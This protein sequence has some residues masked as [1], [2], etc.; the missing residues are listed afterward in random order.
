M[1]FCFTSGDSIYHAVKTMH[2]NL[3]NSTSAVQT[4]VIFWARFRFFFLLAD[5]FKTFFFA[6]AFGFRFARTNWFTNVLATATTENRAEEFAN[7]WTLIAHLWYLLL[8]AYVGVGENVQ[9][10]PIG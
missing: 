9:V 2:T 1:H 10:V 5:A 6:F 8:S 3:V 7:S 4:T